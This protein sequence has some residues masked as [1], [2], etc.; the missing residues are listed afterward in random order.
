[1]SILFEVVTQITL[2]IVLLAAAG[3]GLQKWAS[4]DIQTLNRLLVYATFPCF[5]VVTL[6]Q[7]EIPLSQVQGAAAFTLGQFL[8]LLAL[9][10]WVGTGLGLR[11]DLR[12]VVAIACA[13]PNSGN[14]GIP[15]IE[16]AFGQD[17]VIHQVVITAIYS[18]V[19]LFSA[20]LL[21]AGPEGGVK[22]HLK[23]LFATPMIPAVALGL[24][25]NA[26]NWR[27][28]EVIET[29]METLGQGYVGI[30]LFA[31]GAQLAASN[32]KV[33]L[34]TAGVAVGLRLLLAPALT[35]LA[36]LAVPL[37]TEVQHLLIV[38][39]CAPV[40]VLVAIFAAEFRGNVELSSAVV[41][42]STLL[43]PLMVT[44]VLVMIRL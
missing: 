28:P 25:L 35:A 3:Y 43:S 33:P 17:L 5:I 24:G 40:G 37:S 2:P 42:A 26:M 11:R 44:A 9:G 18:V 38:G 14:F 32:L 16:L 23:T 13:F 31:L 27:L 20:P 15:V 36:M 6:S 1:M 8:F 41:I 4:F 39:A 22:K 30:A 19:I 10:W 12:A 34:G 29:P 21:F 7:A